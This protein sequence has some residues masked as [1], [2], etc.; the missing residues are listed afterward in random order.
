[1][2]KQKHVDVP[3]QGPIEHLEPG[4]RTHLWQRPSR[5]D[6]KA[7]ES[8]DTDYP[9]ELPRWVHKAGADPKMVHTP[10]QCDEALADGWE[11]HPTTAV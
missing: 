8:T 9:H 2:A 11:I 1:M 5:V 6:E 4:E 7:D 3:S 10:A